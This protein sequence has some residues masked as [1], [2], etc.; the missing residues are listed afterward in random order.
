MDWYIVRERRNS[1]VTLET[2]NIR[3]TGHTPST[4][5]RKTQN[6]TFIDLLLN[7]SLKIQMDSGMFITRT[8][9]FSIMMYQI[10]NGYLIRIIVK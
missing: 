2:E 4:G 6:I 8:V 10:S 5:T 3:S 1:R 7:I 9:M